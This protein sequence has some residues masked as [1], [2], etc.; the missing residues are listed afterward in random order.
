MQ[1]AQWTFSMLQIPLNFHAP[2]HSEEGTRAFRIRELRAAMP[3]G[4]TTCILK[5][6]V[7]ETAASFDSLIIDPPLND[8]RC[9]IH[10][11]IPDPLNL[12]HP[13]FCF[14]LPPP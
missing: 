8:E 14:E 9:Q 2:P 5:F 7:R 6:Q 13:P 3:K 10:R 1:D 11:R 4:H 12:I